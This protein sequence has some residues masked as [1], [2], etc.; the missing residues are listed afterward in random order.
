MKTL[1][2]LL[3]FIFIGCSS[4]SANSTGCPT[5]KTYSTYGPS[6]A[7]IAHLNLSDGTSTDLP[8]EVVEK[9]VNDTYLIGK[10][11]CK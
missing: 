11:F 5:I 10:T 6:N 4:D 2:L 9:R 3:A 8:L 1:I 7:R